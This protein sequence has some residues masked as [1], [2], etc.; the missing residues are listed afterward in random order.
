[1]AYIQ[2]GIASDSLQKNTTVHL[3]LPSATRD[4]HA[5][6]RSIEALYPEDGRFPVLYL[7]HGSLGG[8]DDWLRRTNVERYAEKHRLALVMP[9]A[10]NS[11]YT[12]MHRGENYLS[13]ITQEL[14]AFMRTFF[15]LSQRRED[16]F[17]AGLSMGG[18]GAFLAA[19]TAPG[20][21]S[22]AAS[23]SGSLDI[24]A[25]MRE[26]KAQGS[27]MPRNYMRA[28]FEDPLNLPDSYHLPA[29]LRKRLA[30]GVQLPEL[31]MSCGLDD[32]TL[33]VNDRF[34]EEASET[35]LSL[36]YE[37]H[38]GGHDWDYWDEHIKNVIDWV[39]ADHA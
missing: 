4:D 14:P 13:Y 10:E 37:K 26:Q 38:P 3:V 27:S 6:A 9:S 24:R 5:Q 7:L 30:Q 34:Y 2:C 18:Y 33:P 17:I 31:F 28:L 21:F 35:G 12:D 19:L 8:G 29:L 25:F 16:T 36:T 11:R 1:M 23:L 32:Q 39:M 20:T 22:R 15:P